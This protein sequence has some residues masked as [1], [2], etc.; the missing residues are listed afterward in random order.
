MDRKRTF[1]LRSTAEYKTLETEFAEMA[2]KGWLI[3]KINPFSCEYRKAKKRNLRFC[4]DLPPQISGLDYPHNET[5]ND[6]RALCEDA[7]WAFVCASG[8]LQVFSAEDESIAPLH[9]DPELERR[10]LTD[11][12]VKRE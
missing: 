8:Q 9:T 1:A 10:I 2:A 6:Y 7:G 12:F 5:A 4:V 3:D 11:I